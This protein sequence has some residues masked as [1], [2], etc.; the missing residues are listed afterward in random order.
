M[1]SRSSVKAFWARV[2]GV[3][4]PWFLGVSL[5]WAQSQPVPVPSGSLPVSNSARVVLTVKVGSRQTTWTLAQ[6]EG[7]GVHRVQTATFWPDDDGV[8]EGP[9]LADVLAA[10]GLEDAERLRVTAKDGFSQ[11]IAREDWSTWPLLLA[12]RRSGQLL[13]TRQKGPLRVIYPRDMDRRLA[14]PVYRLRWVWMVSQM[15]AVR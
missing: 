4:V 8:Y 3:V 2:L 5:V 9:R 6:L 7:L 12:T 14:D 1:Q 13:S 11:V 10:S 15:E